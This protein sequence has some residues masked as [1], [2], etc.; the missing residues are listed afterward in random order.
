MTE[1]RGGGVSHYMDH[2]P[3][4]AT[5]LDGDSTIRGSVDD[6]DLKIMGDMARHL[7]ERADEAFLHP[8]RARAR[9]AAREPYDLRKDIRENGERSGLHC[10]GCRNRHLW[11]Q[12]GDGDY[13]M[14]PTYWCRPEDGGCDSTWSIG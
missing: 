8:E 4:R 3:I 13:H 5:Y 14:G 6:L 9:E 12:A 1:E 11:V 10:H 7:A 2:L